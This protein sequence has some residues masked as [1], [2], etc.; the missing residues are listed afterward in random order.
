MR[1]VLIKGG[2]GS[3]GSEIVTQMI[4]DSIHQIYFKFP[5]KLFPASTKSCNP[6]KFSNK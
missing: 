1:N 5:K 4:N 6:R 3:L 2:T